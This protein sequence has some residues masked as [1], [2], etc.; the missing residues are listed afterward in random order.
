[1]PGDISVSSCKTYRSWWGCS[2]RASRQSKGPLTRQSRKRK[3]RCTTRINISDNDDLQRRGAAMVGLRLPT[4]FA[5]DLHL[6]RLVVQRIP[7]RK[8]MP[9]LMSENETDEKAKSST[10]GQQAPI[11]QQ[12]ATVTLKECPVPPVCS[13]CCSSRLL[14]RARQS[15]GRPGRRLRCGSHSG[16]ADDIRCPQSKASRSM[17]WIGEAFINRYSRA[18]ADFR[19]EERREKNV[20]TALRPNKRKAPGPSAAL[21]TSRRCHAVERRPTRDSR[22]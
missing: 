18:P 12:L 2:G 17:P 5:K 15:V 7:D 16:R 3:I 9:R 10:P 14:S 21:V 20:S 1:M 13:N 22:E 6:A 4:D 19:D 8:N 11:R